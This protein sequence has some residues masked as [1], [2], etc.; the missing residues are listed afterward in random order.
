MYNGTISEVGKIGVSCHEEFKRLINVYKIVEKYTKRL[1]EGGYKPEEPAISDGETEE[2]KEDREEG[3]QH[4]G[5]KD[6]A[7]DMESLG[8]GNQNTGNTQINGNAQ[9]SSVQPGIPAPNQFLG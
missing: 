9:A 6:S 4:N 5:Q 7:L 3:N 2:I 8:L 1:D